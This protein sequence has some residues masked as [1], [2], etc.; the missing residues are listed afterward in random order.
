MSQGDRKI[1]D[2]VLRILHGARGLPPSEAIKALRPFLNEMNSRIPGGDRF[3]DASAMAVSDLVLSL[4]T[5]SIAT[6]D[7]WLDAIQT[8][9]S[10]ADAAD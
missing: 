9:L 7:I 8:T 1:A 2:D 10:L 3:G 6:D 5:K 4:E